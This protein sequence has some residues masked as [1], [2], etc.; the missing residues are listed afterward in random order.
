MRPADLVLCAFQVFG[1]RGQSSGWG[2][3]RISSSRCPVPRQGP[4][5]LTQL[6]TPG[7][8]ET[9]PKGEC[10]PPPASCRRDVGRKLFGG[11]QQV[12]EIFFWNK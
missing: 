5:P 6:L 12:K 2:E 1:K 4:E 8:P 9:V 7:H 11:S 10:G 3:V